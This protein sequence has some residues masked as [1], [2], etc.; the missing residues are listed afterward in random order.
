MRKEQRL[1]FN[2]DYPSEKSPLYSN[3]NVA[4]GWCFHTSEPI[5]A[6]RLFVNKDFESEGILKY[7]RLDV[8]SKYPDHGESSLLCGFTCYF[9]FAKLSMGEN[10]FDFHVYTK[11][12]QERIS[13]VVVK[14]GEPASQKVN[15]VFVDILLIYTIGGILFFI[16]NLAK[17]ST[18]VAVRTSK[19]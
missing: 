3:I 7:P 16:Q 1:L 2:I 9:N 6:I 15:D 12:S 8:A 11:H 5:Y 13:K 17:S 14:H 19:L 4:S 18:S 10:L